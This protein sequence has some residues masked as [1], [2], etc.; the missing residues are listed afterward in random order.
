[1]RLLRGLLRSRCL[2]RAL[3]AHAVRGRRGILLGK[4]ENPLKA[5]DQRGDLSLRLDNL[6]RGSVARCLHFLH[7]GRQLGGH[8]REPVAL[9]LLGRELLLE[10]HEARLRLRSLLACRI[11]EQRSRNKRRLGLLQALRCRF[12]NLPSSVEPDAHRFQGGE[13]GF[14]GAYLQDKGV[15]LLVLLVLR[16]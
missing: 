1:M 13:L 16:L 2:R 12:G 6:L 4:L 15:S 3:G 11:P 14:D 8:G 9:G 10:L 7:D 5:R